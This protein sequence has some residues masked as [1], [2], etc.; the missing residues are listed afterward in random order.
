MKLEDSDDFDFVFKPSFEDDVGDEADDYLVAP[1]RD[2]EFFKRAFYSGLMSQALAK[3]HNR[4]I[5]GK[6]VKNMFSSGLQGVW[7]VPG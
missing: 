3:R 6:R 2:R 5:N 1:P 4:V 7:G